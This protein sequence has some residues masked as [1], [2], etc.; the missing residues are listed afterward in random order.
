MVFRGFDGLGGPSYK[1]FAH[2]AKV[3]RIWVDRKG[4]IGGLSALVVR[5]ERLGKGGQ[6]A[7]GTL[8]DLPCYPR[9]KT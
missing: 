8:L 1:A 4:A 5:M 6:A 2:L 9:I 3:L 7:H